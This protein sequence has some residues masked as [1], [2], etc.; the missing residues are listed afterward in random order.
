ML[1]EVFAPGSENL[2]GRWA[3]P[4]SF[5]FLIELTVSIPR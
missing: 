2:A 4:M 1:E 5:R 3:G